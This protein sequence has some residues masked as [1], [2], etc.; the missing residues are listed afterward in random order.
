MF[1]VWPMCVTRR[2]VDDDI[3]LTP[4]GPMGERDR[5]RRRTK[6]TTYLLLGRW[7]RRLNPSV[8][9]F[10]FESKIRVFLYSNNIVAV[11]YF[12]GDTSEHS[13]GRVLVFGNVVTDV[14]VLRGSWSARS[15]DWH[16]GIVAET[17]DD[18]PL[19]EAHAVPWPGLAVV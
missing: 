15:A 4:Y 8:H 13:T 5:M 9:E 11:N 18:P 10:P 16:N 17:P 1:H 14:A 7:K 2:D 6:Q 12:S 3:S 19:D